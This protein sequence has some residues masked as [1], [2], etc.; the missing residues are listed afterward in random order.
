MSLVD[1]KLINWILSIL[2]LPDSGALKDPNNIFKLF[3]T[4][5][6]ATNLAI[7]S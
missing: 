7:F 2:P 1:K 5:C 6:M 4:T 3:Q